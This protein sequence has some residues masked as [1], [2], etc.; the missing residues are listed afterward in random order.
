MGQ[1]LAAYDSNGNIYTYYDSVDSPAPDGASTIEISYAQWQTCLETPGYM[2]KSGQLVAPTP[3]TAAQ[4]LANAQL[5]LC[6][7]IDAAADAAY[8]QIGGPSPGRLA[9]YQQAYADAQTFKGAGYTGTVPATVQCWATAANMTTQQAAD[10]IISTASAWSNVL[11][12]IRSARLIGKANVN[13]ATT[14]AAAQAAQAQAIAN[15]QTAAA[16]A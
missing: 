11:T 9:E 2:V 14:V 4:Q 16:G 13:A 1:K 5:D 6:A 7:S 12:G 8:I 3:P 10:S 15:I